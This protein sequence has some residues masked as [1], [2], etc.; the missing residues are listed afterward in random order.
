MYTSV[1]TKLLFGR[2]DSN[3]SVLLEEPGVKC[4]AQREDANSVLLVTPSS[5]VTSS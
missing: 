2:C 1:Q 3:C 5:Q 4:P